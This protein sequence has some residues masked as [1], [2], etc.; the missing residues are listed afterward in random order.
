[1]GACWAW[2]EGPMRVGE[3]WAGQELWSL[4]SKDCSL[5]PTCGPGSVFS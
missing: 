3:A 5:P 1:M 2:M 4:H